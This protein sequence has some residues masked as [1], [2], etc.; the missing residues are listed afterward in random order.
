[1]IPSQEGRYSENL[2]INSLKW[3]SITRE[4]SVS[5]TLWQFQGSIISTNTTNL[6]NR[7]QKSSKPL[8]ILFYYH[9]SYD[10]I[11]SDHIT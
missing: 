4:L 11:Q 6:V 9:K 1:M 5:P 3:L 8:F 2:W 7:D 10:S